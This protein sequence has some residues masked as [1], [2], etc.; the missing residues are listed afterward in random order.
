MN[1]EYIARKVELTDQIRQ[2]TE[3]KL[4]RLEK[5]FN[6]ILDIR[7]EFEQERHLFVVDVVVNGKDFDT[8]SKA[9]NKD[10]R[11]AIQE[12]VDRLEIQARKAKTR[13]KGRKRQG[14]EGSSAPDWSIDVLTPESVS[15]GE[16]RIVKTSTI[17]V[18]PM[19]IDEAMLQLGRS[20]NEF[21]VFLNAATDRVNVLYRR[22]DNNLGL[23]TPEL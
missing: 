1:I 20:R 18:K 4:S 2:L 17:T 3:K 5:Y 21:I 14:E 7:V 19:T 6:Q 15:S 9:Q 22:Q 13:L 8:R 23:I 16:P 12:A 10:L 11:T